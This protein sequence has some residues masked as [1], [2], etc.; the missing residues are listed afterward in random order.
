MKPTFKDFLTEVAVRRDDPDMQDYYSD[1]DQTSTEQ[2]D[3]PY[4]VGWSGQSHEWYGD[5]GPESGQGRYKPKG[6]GGD[7]VA[8]NVPDYQTA[9]QIQSQLDKSYE[10]NTFH[11]KSVYGKHGKDWYIVDYDSSYIIP[12]KD[13]EEWQLKYTKAKDYSSQGQ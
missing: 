11:D 4:A 5:E 2:R 8:I 13:V 9:T 3:A 1:Q 7:Y 12:M 6:D 10:E